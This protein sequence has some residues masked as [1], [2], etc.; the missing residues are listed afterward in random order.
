MLLEHALRSVTKANIPTYVGGVTSGFLGLLT[1]N[2]NVSIS[3]TLTGGAAS[4]PAENDVIIVVYSTGSVGNRNIAVVSPG[5]LLVGEKDYSNDTYDNNLVIYAKVAGATAEGNVVVGPT[6]S[7]TDGGVV[8]VHVWR[9][10]DTNIIVEKVEQVSIID[11]ALLNPPSIT[12]ITSGAVILAGG[13][14]GHIAGSLVYSTTTS[15]ALSNFVQANSGNDTYDSTVAIGNAVWT[16]GA[17]DVGAFTLTTGTN[18]TTYSN[19]SFALALKPQ[20]TE[21]NEYPDYIDSTDIGGVGT[22]A[23]VTKPTNTTSGDLIVIFVVVEQNTPLTVTP[24]SGFT[25]SNTYDGTG[26]VIWTLTKTAGGSEPADY[27]VSWLKSGAAVSLKYAV[28]CVTL[29][30]ATTTGAVYGTVSEVNATSTPTAPALTLSAKGI[31]FSLYAAKSS[32]AQVYPPSLCTKIEEVPSSANISFFLFYRK[33]LNVN[34]TGLLF[35]PDTTGDFV[36][37][38]SFFPRA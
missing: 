33:H 28:A 1:G 2:T 10:I 22:S 25:T 26:Q 21:V 4:S 8:A 5:Y 24:P 23:T 36:S 37:Q 11:T 6:L 18:A 34:S 31:L 15:P 30:N 3:G 29:R 13:G 9:N 32:I 12:P 16:S 35:V 17:F 7:T 27:T 14:S 19:N 20:S 38:Q